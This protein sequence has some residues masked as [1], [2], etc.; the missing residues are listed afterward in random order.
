MDGQHVRLSAQSAFA[1]RISSERGHHRPGSPARRDPA[2]G[3][4][5]GA[6][7]A[8]RSGRCETSFCHGLPSCRCVSTASSSKAARQRSAIARRIISRASPNAVARV[9]GN[10]PRAPV[11]S[12]HATR[13]SRATAARLLL[14]CTGAR[15]HQA[16]P[17]KVSSALQ[18]PPSGARRRPQPA[19]RSPSLHARR[20]RSRRRREAGRHPQARYSAAEREPD[21]RGEPLRER[22]QPSATT[23]PPRTP[24]ILGG[25]LCGEVLQR[26]YDS[27]AMR[28]R[29]ASSSSAAAGFRR[30]R[31]EQPV[32]DEG[33]YGAVAVRQGG[34]PRGSAAPR[35]PSRPSTPPPPSVKASIRSR[36]ARR[37]PAPART[38]VSRPCGRG[39][40]RPCPGS[41]PSTPRNLW[42]ITASFRPLL[43]GFLHRPR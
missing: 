18:K 33:F 30:R 24:Q 27:R 37:P 16:Q 40:G 26:I 6:T 14:C 4:R 9:E 2:L 31:L 36:A 21:F 22:R 34:A 42:Y 11:K 3:P 28:R 5:L 41:M 25:R 7:A 13:G 23:A 38:A 1:L 43:G 39:R 12:T 32:E 20:R 35:R 10:A 19:R 17:R 29:T 15:A 8:G